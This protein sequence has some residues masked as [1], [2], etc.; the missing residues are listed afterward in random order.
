MTPQAQF[1]HDIGA[2]A[3]EVDVRIGVSIWGSGTGTPAGYCQHERFPLASVAKFLTAVAAVKRQE[4]GEIASAADLS[5][6]LMLAH[7]G[8]DRR[9]RWQAD[10]SILV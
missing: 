6:L 1:E 5:N 8:G 4:E 10:V 3:R 9:A 7:A 2:I